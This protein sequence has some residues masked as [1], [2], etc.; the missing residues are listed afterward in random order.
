MPQSFMRAPFARGRRVLD[1]L[2]S[3]EK[4]RAGYGTVQKMSH[5]LYP[6]VGAIQDVTTLLD[7]TT[8]SDFIRFVLDY[9]CLV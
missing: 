2:R 7:K 3:Y 9:C 4:N 1:K 6:Y 5:V 8:L